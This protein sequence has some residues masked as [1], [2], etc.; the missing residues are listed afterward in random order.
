MQISERVFALLTVAI[1]SIFGLLVT[2]LTNKMVA[3]RERYAFHRQLHRERLEATRSLYEDALFMLEK[4]IVQEG[5]VNKVEQSEFSRVIARLYL[6]STGDICNKFV[7]AVELAQ[8]WSREFGKTQPHRVGDHVII[9]SDLYGV[10]KQAAAEADKLLTTF[11][12][13]L[14][15]LRTEMIAHLSELEKPEI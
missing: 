8:A 12:Q 7:Q 14:A 9:T 4:I 6:R 10:K 3:S 11:Q 2:I 13:S 15:V 5:A 1:S